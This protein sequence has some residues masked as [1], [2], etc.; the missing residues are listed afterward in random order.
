MFIPASIVSTKHK[1]TKTQ[2]NREQDGDDIRNGLLARSQSNEIKSNKAVN[3]SSERV[4]SCWLGDESR[5]IFDGEKCELLGF[6]Y[7]TKAVEFI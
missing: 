2:R 3:S 6:I 4:K 1:D 7:S 5:L